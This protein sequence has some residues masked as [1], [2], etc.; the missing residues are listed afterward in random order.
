MIVTI[1]S[2]ELIPIRPI[3]EALGID[4]LYQVRKIKK[5]EDLSSVMVLNATIRYGKEYKTLCSHFEVVAGWLFTINPMNV[6]PERVLVFTYLKQYYRDLCE[7]SGW[8]P[9]DN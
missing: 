6:K 9:A 2:E 3:C 5:D 4:Y 1:D 7:K 8:I